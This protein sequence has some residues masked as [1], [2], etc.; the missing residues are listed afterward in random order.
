[1]TNIKKHFQVGTHTH[2]Q[3]YAHNESYFKTFVNEIV[4]NFS[5]KR[6]L[7]ASQHYSLL[8]LISALVLW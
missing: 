8:N 2:T 3:M 4:H 6:K 1:M 7:H 5:P